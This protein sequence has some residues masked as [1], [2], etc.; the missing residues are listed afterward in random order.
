MSIFENMK[1]KPCIKCGSTDIQ[2]NADAETKTAY[3][4]CNGCGCDGNKKTADFIWHAEELACR[5]WN[6]HNGDGNA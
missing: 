4:H 2:T 6:S 5:D 1:I 3:I